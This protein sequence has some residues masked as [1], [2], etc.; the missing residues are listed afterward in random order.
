LKK[1]PEQFVSSMEELLGSE[2]G[3]FFDALERPAVKGLRVNRLKLTPE[4]FVRI[5][6]FQLKGAAFC[7]DGFVV[8][9]DCGAGRHPY[10]H[11]G[12]Y[13]MQEPSAMS[14]VTALDPRPG[15]RVLDLCA[16]PGGK[17]TQILSAMRGRGM[18]VANEAVNKRTAALLS[19][20]ER[21]GAGNCV[22]T[23]LMPDELAEHFEGWF[24]RVLVDAPCSGE[25]LFRRDGEAAGQ[26]TAGHS[27]ACAVRQGKILEE[28]ARALRGGGVLVYSTCTFA[29]EENEGV[30]G[31]FLKEHSEFE[32]EPT[33]LERCAGVVPCGPDGLCSRLYPHRCEGEGHFVARMRKKGEGG[34]ELP[35]FSPAVG[36][37][38]RAFAQWYAE[39]FTGEPRGALHAADGWVYILPEGLPVLPR[40]VVRAGILAARVERG[41]VEPAHSLYISSKYDEIIR[42]V[43][44]SAESPDLARYL[45]GETVRAGIP[46]GWCSVCVDGYPL[47]AGKA[48]GGVVKNH[49]PKGLRTLK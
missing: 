36:E 33:G 7:P 16:A 34:S 35:P 38:T 43:D 45:H 42:K 8:G 6:P 4:E 18:V 41:R 46:D 19:N 13:Y 31:S 27:A 20:V 29:E 24:D 30:V 14:A 23:S 22:I 3:A 48:V 12:L 44:F 10:H 40:G 37:E 21:W 11:A 26:W 15:E 25:G 32:P 17:T 47:T 49:Y 39:N 9:G 28:A 1:F 5:S 2:S